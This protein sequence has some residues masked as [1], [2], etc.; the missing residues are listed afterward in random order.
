[1]NHSLR[2]AALLAIVALAAGLPVHAGT[3]E[4]SVEERGAGPVPDQTVSLY[5]VTPEIQVDPLYFF[6]TR[7]VGRCTTGPTGRCRVA[8]LRV[9]VYFP[10]LFPIA[11]PNL[12]APIGPPMVAYG[13]VTLAKPDALARLRVELQRGVRIQFR[14]V[15][16][17]AAIPTRSRVEL[18]NDGGE[19]ADA[20]FDA[21]GRAQITLSSGRWLAHLAGPA[22][23]RIVMVELDGGELTT[24]DVPIE[25]VAPSS[26]RFVTWTLS[27]PC[28]VRGRVTTNTGER[29]RVAIQATLVAP[30]PWGASALCRATTCAPPSTTPVDPTGNYVIELPSGTWRIAPT[31]ESL[32]ESNP[33]FVELSCGEGQNVRADFDIREKDSGVGPKAV[34]VVRVLGAD[35]RPL[36]GVPVEVWPSTGNLEVS[37]PIATETTDGY[38]GL[39][40]FTKLSAGGYLLRA[41][42][43]GYRIAVEAVSGLDPEASAPRH[44]T[45]RLDRGAT[46]DA[47]ATDEKDRP[48]TGVGL[49]VKRIVASPA[50]DDPAT[51]LAESDVE[52]SVPPSKDQTGHVVVTG[53]AG[54]TYDVTPVLSGAAASTAVIGIVAGEGTAEKSVVLRLDEH[55]RKE[56]SVRVRPAASLAGH[57]VCADGGLLPKQA[58]ACVLGLPSGDED[59][60][61]REACK[62]P[63]IPSATVTLSGDRQDAFVVGPLTPGSFRLALRPRGYTSWTWVLGTPDGAQAAVVQVNGSDA[64]EL[65]TIPVLCGPAVELRPTV[66]SRDPLPDLTLAVVSAQLTRTSP[67]G[68]VE[69]RVVPAERS[70]ERVAIRELSEGEWTLDVT[71]SHPFFVPALPVRLSV[72]VKL[73]RGVQLRAGVQIVAV[74]GAVAIDASAG[75]ARLSGPDGLTRL[76]SAKD[77]RIAI[78]GVAPGAYRVELCEDVSCARILRR[79]DAVQVAR[80]KKALLAIADDPSTRSN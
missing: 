42:S 51:R 33:P 44:V 11:D 5:P 21:S 56:V 55:D 68:K 17:N 4:V 65:G 74:G 3:I 43:P 9:G 47:L 75:T 69:R 58:D 10:W 7:P 54:G 22:G 49:K 48:V 14:V 67:E 8:E 80:G 77:G 37:R 36:P 60:A 38:M 63:V 52:L 57:L 70:R 64:V 25:L 40:N 30:G 27:P 18:S 1:M 41:R 39:A 32:L 59:D 79:W 23:A 66:L 31:G 35:D 71:M 12:A 53:L 15:S 29:P 45:I 13:T 50:S 61:T 34:L 76:E 78:D 24:V 28:R 62:S 20:A 46:I 16:E 2:A 6:N 73:E 26:D 19:K 72:P